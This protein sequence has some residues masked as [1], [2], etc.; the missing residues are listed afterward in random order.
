MLAPIFT[1]LETQYKSSGKGEIWMAS[2]D[3]S[4]EKNDLLCGNQQPRPQPAKRQ[5]HQMGVPNPEVIRKIREGG[6]GMGMRPAKDI[7]PYSATLWMC[8]SC[9][10]TWD[11]GK[12]CA[13]CGTPRLQEQEGWL[14]SCG[15]RG[16]AAVCSACGSP[17]PNDVCASCGWTPADAASASA[18]CPECGCV[19]RQD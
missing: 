16:R 8:P 18:F 6:A 2:F 7:P 15:H 4:H 9:G 10:K 11:K 5:P 12:F 3:R 1:K 14:C 17:K 19:I 13:E